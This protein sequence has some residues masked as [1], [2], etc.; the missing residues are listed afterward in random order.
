MGLRICYGSQQVQCCL[1]GWVPTPAILKGAPLVLTLSQRLS[2]LALWV[3]PRVSSLCQCISGGRSL[4]AATAASL[5]V[6][7]VRLHVQDQAGRFF[8][9]PSSLGVVDSHLSSITRSNL[10]VIMSFG[11]TQLQK[12]G[13]I[14]E[15]IERL[16][17]RERQR[18]RER[19]R[20]WGQGRD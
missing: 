11:E 19:W 20:N 16:R 3:S 10:C 5:G 18:T 6:L 13:M 4:H 2:L 15:K 14:K 17:H 8:F 12:E 1:P 7:A 9:L